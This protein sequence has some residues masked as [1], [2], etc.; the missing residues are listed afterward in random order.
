MLQPLLDATVESHKQDE[1]MRAIDEFLAM[2]SHELRIPVS[3]I[4]GWA[5]ML[6]NRQIDHTDFATA[7]KVIRRNALVQ[8]QLIDALTDY[9]SLGVN[10]FA[11]TIRAVSLA[12]IVNAAVEALAPMAREKQI[13]VEMQFG[14]STAEMDGDP[15][16]LLQVF[17]NLL[18]NAIK[19]TVP[20]TFRLKTIGQ[21]FIG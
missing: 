12:Q 21:K 4:L 5:E 14:H 7:I 17:L 8:V 1:S 6:D 13:H 16:R 2:I 9:A 10:E 15:T 11:L 18:S 20:L 3:A 19:F